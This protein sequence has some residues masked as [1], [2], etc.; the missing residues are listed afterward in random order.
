MLGNVLLLYAVN[1]DHTLYPVLAEFVIEPSDCC[2]VVYT[3]VTD[4][5][6]EIAD[7]EPD[8]KTAVVPIKL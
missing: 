1:P 5:G 7:N 3:N 2:K 8:V 4:A 6:S